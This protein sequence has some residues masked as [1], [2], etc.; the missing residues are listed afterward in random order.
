MRSVAVG[1]N[2]S[3]IFNRILRHEA[4][5]IFILNAH[6]EACSVPHLQE[7]KCELTNRITC[8]PYTIILPMTELLTLIDVLITEIEATGICNPSVNNHDFSVV[9]VVVLHG[10]YRC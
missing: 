9:A 8:N 1:D 3:V 2:H 6:V 4:V 5:E 10:K 7:H